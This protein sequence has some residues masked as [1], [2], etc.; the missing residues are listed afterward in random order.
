[1]NEFRKKPFEGTC[2]HKT[3]KDSGHLNIL[4]FR[5]FNSPKIFMDE[6][7]PFKKHTS[8]DEPRIFNWTAWKWIEKTPQPT[9]GIQNLDPNQSRTNWRLFFS[10]FGWQVQGRIIPSRPRKLQKI[11]SSCSKKLRIVWSFLMNKQFR[12]YDFHSH[13]Q[14]WWRETSSLFNLNLHIRSTKWGIS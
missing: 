12:P 9:T 8:K 5:V 13:P 10:I 7:L 4:M 14:E 3:T 11:L 6:H 2:R 1:M